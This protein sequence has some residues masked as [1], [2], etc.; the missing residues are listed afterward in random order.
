MPADETEIEWYTSASGL[1]QWY[2]HLLECNMNTIQTNTEALIGA[3]REVGFEENI[4]IHIDFSYQK[5]VKIM[6]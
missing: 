2:I 3:S 5:Q 6:P 4:K 1:R